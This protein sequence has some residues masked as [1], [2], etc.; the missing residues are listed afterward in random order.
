MALL[1][2]KTDNIIHAGESLIII[3]ANVLINVI[4]GGLDSLFDV[5]HT[6]HNNNGK[7]I[8]IIIIMLLVEGVILY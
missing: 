5:L 8:N 3:I 4:G 1:L 7:C 2:L 6:V